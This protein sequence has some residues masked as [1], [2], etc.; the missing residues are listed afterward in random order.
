LKLNLELGGRKD[1]LGDAEIERPTALNCWKKKRLGGERGGWASVLGSTTNTEEKSASPNRGRKM[2]RKGLEEGLAGKTKTRK[3]GERI[4]PP[5]MIS[6]WVGGVLLRGRLRWKREKGVK[7]KLDFESR[8]H[9][10]GNGGSAD[11]DE[12]GRHPLRRFILRPGA[13]EQKK[14]IMVTDVE[15]RKALADVRREIL[16]KNALQS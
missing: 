13:T 15:E 7:S 10:L 5:S 9:A 12:T 4:P 11:E 8:K 14:L 3:A 16:K 6:A 1:I 2:P